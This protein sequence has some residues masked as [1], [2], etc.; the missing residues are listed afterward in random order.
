M[1]SPEEDQKQNNQ[2]AVHRQII[3][4][5]LHHYHLLQNKNLYQN[6][7]VEVSNDNQAN[8][9]LSDQKQEAKQ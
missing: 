4:V 5:L 9:H 6:Q 1:L 2:Q 3:A 8:N 7:E